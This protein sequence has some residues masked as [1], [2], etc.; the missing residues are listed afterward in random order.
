MHP[1]ILL[2]KKNQI[3]R[4]LVK[5]MLSRQPCLDPNVLGIHVWETRVSRCSF[6]RCDQRHGALLECI[7]HTIVT[8]KRQ[9]SL[10]FSNTSRLFAHLFS[11]RG[12]IH[13]LVYPNNC[14]PFLTSGTLNVWVNYQVSGS[15]FTN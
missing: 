13:S 14:N 1:I 12:P 2:K 10:S 9:Q 7:N 8:A 3:G 5:I 11:H 6:T 15:L 4:P